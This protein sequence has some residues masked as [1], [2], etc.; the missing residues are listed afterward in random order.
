[1]EVNIAIF[2]PWSFR[3]A[4]AARQGAPERGGGTP[5]GSVLPDRTR[6]PPLLRAEGRTA[7][8]P[9]GLEMGGPFRYNTGSTV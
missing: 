4:G 9:P 6:R 8:A 2:V 1:M 7:T 3:Q 5:E